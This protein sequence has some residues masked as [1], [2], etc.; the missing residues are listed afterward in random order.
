MPD[1]QPFPIPEEIDPPKM[2]LQLCIPDDPT[3]KRVINGLL[4]ELGQWYNWQ[5]DDA[6]S[7]KQLAQVWRQ[8][9]NDIDWSDMSCC[10]E[11]KPPLRFRF[12]ADGGYQ[13]S[14]DGGITWTDAP[15]WDYRLTSVLSPSLEDQG[16]SNTKCQ[17]ADSVIVQYRDQIV[18]EIN[19]TQGA[20]AILALIAAVLLVFLTAGSALIIASMPGIVGAILAVG[21]AAM[22]AAFTEEVWDQF[23]CLVYCR[24][25]SDDSIGEAG[26]KALIQ[27]VH[28]NFEG[29][30]NIVLTNLL[31]AT[32]AI[33]LTN[34][35][36][37]AQGDPESDCS[38]CECPAPCA[39]EGWWG[40]M[41][42]EGAWYERSVFITSDEN[43]ITLGS[44]DRGDGQQIIAFSVK[45]RN[46]CC[47]VQWEWVGDIPDPALLFYTQ[48]GTPADYSDLEQN[49][50]MGDCNEVTSYFFQM[51]E[52][53]WT[54]K[55]TFVTDCD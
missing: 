10:P 19:E 41:W 14:D 9:Y 30:V 25:D 7:G 6:K 4:S 23:R 17:A 24:M 34:M 37:S 15:E 53:S 38:E 8:V 20:S 54:A 29:I 35:M 5:R 11:T 44:V 40:Y 26:W 36:R 22:Q 42:F 21:V 45:D 33:G 12:T 31:N 13:K 49:Q 48:C 39:P 50:L 52:G 32:G 1:R 51:G 3:W 55:F 16:I 43:S 18:E 47:L 28:D 2:C 27:D 46:T